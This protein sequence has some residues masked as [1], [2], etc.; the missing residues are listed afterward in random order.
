MGKATSV[1]RIPHGFNTS[2]LSS[3]SL[4]RKEKEDGQA[5]NLFQYFSF[6]K[7]ISKITKQDF[8]KIEAAMF[9]YF[10]FIKPISKKSEPSSVR[11]PMKFQYFSFIKPISKEN[12]IPLSL[13]DELKKVSILLFY[14][15]YL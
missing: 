7:P 14:Q 10:S 1:L 2:L 12:A 3:L 8:K 5:E 6:I 4:K 15:A 13:L 11:N 9:Q